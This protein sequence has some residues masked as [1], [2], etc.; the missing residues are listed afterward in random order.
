MSFA[1]EIIELP[2]KFAFLK[3]Y[4][5]SLLSVPIETFFLD[6]L[7]SF[8]GTRTIGLRSNG[9]QNHIRDFAHSKHRTT[10]ALNA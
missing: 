1:F 9:A 2:T 10:D 8:Q 6:I 3:N 7:F 5:M 4:L